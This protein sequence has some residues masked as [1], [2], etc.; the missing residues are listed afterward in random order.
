MN[1]F[2][3]YQETAIT[4][5]SRG[6]LVVML[7]DGAI[8]FLRQAVQ[9]L[10]RNDMAAKGNHISKAQDILFELNTVLNM[11]QGGQVAQNLRSLYTFMHRH[12]SEANLQKD[13][14][15]IQEV[16]GILEELNQGWRT[17]AN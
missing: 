8:K 17:I 12:L 11:E 13:S 10:Q 9:D 15:K 7:Y 14:R 1:G 3:T 16:I 2:N 5:Q 6:R 4:T